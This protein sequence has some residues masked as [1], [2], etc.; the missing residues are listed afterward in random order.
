MPSYWGFSFR[1]WLEDVLKILEEPM[2]Q[3][4]KHFIPEFL[5]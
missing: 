5:G 3:T 2:E 1:E 4:K